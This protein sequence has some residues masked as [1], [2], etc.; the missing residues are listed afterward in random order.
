MV[1]AVLPQ[2]VALATA[3]TEGA[4]PWADLAAEAFLAR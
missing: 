2:S 1:T 3:V 4:A